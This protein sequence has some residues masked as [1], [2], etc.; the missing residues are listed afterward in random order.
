M[1]KE[2]CIKYRDEADND[3]DRE[4]WDARIKRKYPTQVVVKEEKVSEKPSKAKKKTIK[5]V[6]EE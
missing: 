5:E 4:F 3:K 6:V 1:T 2:N